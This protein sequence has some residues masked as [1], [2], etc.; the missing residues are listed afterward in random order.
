MRTATHHHGGPAQVPHKTARS[1][2]SFNAWLSGL[3]SG[4]SVA[5]DVNKMLDDI[6]RSHPM[7]EKVLSTHIEALI[8]RQE[9]RTA[10]KRIRE[11]ESELAKMRELISE[12]QLTGS[13]NR[14]GLNDALERELA[15]ATRRQSPLCVA[16][17]DLD[18][19]KKLNDTHGHCA[20]DAALV[21]VVR[22]IKDTLRKM[23]VIGRFG[24]EEFMILLPDTPLEN[25]VQTLVR[26]QATLSREV[27]EHNGMHLS[28]TFSAGVTLCGDGESQA[29]LVERADGALYRAKKAG[30]NRVFSA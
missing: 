9:M 12:D 13:L 2:S 19:F 6:L 22:V 30:K 3:S 18:D 7:R 10:E 1:E 21:H 27:L 28:I 26:L 25:A 11:L 17:L 16:L 8:A 23:D 24:G 29:E 15:R 20:G 5:S 4:L 14:R